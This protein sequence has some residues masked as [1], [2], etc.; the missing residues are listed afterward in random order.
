MKDYCFDRLKLAKKRKKLKDKRLKLESVLDW[1]LAIDL[2][3]C[4]V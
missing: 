3:D 2:K 4:Y 1:Q